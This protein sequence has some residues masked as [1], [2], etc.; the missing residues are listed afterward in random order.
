MT[1]T[2]S[3]R[4]LTRLCLE[5]LRE[6]PKILNEEDLNHSQMDEKSILLMALYSSL[7]QRLGMQP[8]SIPAY[9]DTQIQEWAYRGELRRLFEHECRM[10]PR[11]DYETV[12]DEFLNEGLKKKKGN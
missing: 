9:P 6:A 1:N 10:K 2:I 12:I 8:R 5:I 7:R 4:E 11:F 3:E